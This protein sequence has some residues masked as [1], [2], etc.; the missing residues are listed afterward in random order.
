[1]YLLTRGAVL[2]HSAPAPPPLP[3][4]RARF[5]GSFD[6]LGWAEVRAGGSFGELALFPDRFGPARLDTAVADS[7]V[8]AYALPA[9][10]FA[11]VAAEFPYAADRLRELCRL[12]LLALL[13]R[14]P[15]PAAAGAGGGGSRAGGLCAVNVRISEAKRDLILMR[16]ARLLA[17]AAGEDGSQVDERRGV[18]GA[19]R[20]LFACFEVLLA[21]WTE[22]IGA[23]TVDAGRC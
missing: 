20:L 18:G 9:A 11:G 21:V 22:P 16:E 14:G 5:S 19:G 10:R 2:L 17:P 3:P 7:D 1:M 8:E 15:G 6:A 4:R 12:R 13:H 23:L